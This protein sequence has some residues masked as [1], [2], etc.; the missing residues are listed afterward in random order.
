MFQVN[1][2]RIYSF[3]LLFIGLDTVHK[4]TIFIDMKNVV[5]LILIKIKR[6]HDT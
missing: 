2:A 4:M 6:Y 3:N 1:K 5:Y